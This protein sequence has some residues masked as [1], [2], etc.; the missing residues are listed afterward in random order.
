MSVEYLYQRRQQA[1]T[2][3][4]LFALR[5]YWWE[6]YRYSVTSNNVGIFMYDEGLSEAPGYS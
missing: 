4:A 3:S 5:S 6:A 1:L 2:R